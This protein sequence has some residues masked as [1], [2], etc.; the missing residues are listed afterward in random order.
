[1]E[2]L[3]HLEILVLV[4]LHPNK[5]RQQERCFLKL[6]W[7]QVYLQKK[8]WQRLQQLQ[9]FQHHL[10]WFRSRS[11]VSNKVGGDEFAGGPLGP[12]GP[13]DFGPG[14]PG[15]FGPGGPGDF[16]PG[17]P[18]DFGPG[19]PEDFGPWRSRRLWSWRSRRL[20][21]WRSRDFGPGG[22]G[23]FGPGGPG[24]FGPGGP[25][26]GDPLSFLGP[27]PDNAATFAPLGGPMD[28]NDP[29]AAFGG[30]VFGDSPIGLSEVPEIL[31]SRRSRCAWRPRTSGGPGI[32]GGPNFD[33]G[34]SWPW[35]RSSIGS[36][37]YVLATRFFFT[38]GHYSTTRCIYSRWSRWICTNRTCYYSSSSWNRVCRR[39][40]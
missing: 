20:W 8:Q 4:V 25:G 10:R 34:S 22:P 12:G 7:P 28:P 13:G 15:D 24:D 35:P 14:G 23:D 40:R 36:N 2:N 3:Y 1:M 29:F 17:G 38:T 37:W 6:H 5:M 9:E 19:G 39:Y 26:V 30:N 27:A 31:T 33:P 18:G 16:G 21:S 32:P 11:F